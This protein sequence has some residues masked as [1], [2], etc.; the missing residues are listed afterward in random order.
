MAGS[1]Y[2]DG[3]YKGELGFQSAVYRDNGSEIGGGQAGT[4]TESF[5]DERTT[6]GAFNGYRNWTEGD[7]EEFPFPMSSY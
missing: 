7:E 6:G 3:R 5:G 2:V 1:F 4:L